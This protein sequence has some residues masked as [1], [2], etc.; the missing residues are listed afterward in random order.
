M[1]YFFSFFFWTWEAFL[2]S[3]AVFLA[4]RGS[5]SPRFTLTVQAGL[6]GQ[7]FWMHLMEHSQHS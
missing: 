4:S 2:I 6:C 7:H 5:S 3:L 1:Y